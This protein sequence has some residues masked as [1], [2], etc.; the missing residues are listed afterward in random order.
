MNVKLG[1]DFLESYPAFQK[2]K[3][4]ALRVRW[5]DKKFLICFLSLTLG[6]LIGRITNTS[7]LFLGNYPE[8]QKYH[9][10]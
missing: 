4:A 6:I 8:R 2:L 5:F 7:N 3:L 1:T 9:T 10:S